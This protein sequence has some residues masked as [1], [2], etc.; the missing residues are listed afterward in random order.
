[1]SFINFLLGRRLASTEKSEQ[2]IGAIAG[3]PTFGLD[4]LASSAYGPEAALTI[5]LPLGAAGLHFIEPITLAI[6]GLL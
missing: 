5:L 6:L 1:M 3:L 2:K 4:G